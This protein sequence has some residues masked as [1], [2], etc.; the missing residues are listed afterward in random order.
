MRLRFDFKKRSRLLLLLEFVLV[1]S[2]GTSS[3][4]ERLNR[5]GKLITN[6][7]EEFSGETE[8]PLISTEARL[9]QSKPRLSYGEHYRH[10][11]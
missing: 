11:R 5:A 3:S 10:P 2:M 8:T 6:V 9:G 1:A 4:R 7:P